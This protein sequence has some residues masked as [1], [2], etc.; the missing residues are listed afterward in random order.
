MIATSYRL[1]VDIDV[2]TVQPHAHNL[3]K[4]IES[5]ATHI[6][7]I[8]EGR[9]QFVEE[10]GQLAERFREV[11]VTLDAPTTSPLNLPGTWLNPEQS[12]VVVRFTDSAYEKERTRAEIH[13]RFSGVREVAARS[14]TLRTMVVALAKSAKRKS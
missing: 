4:Q 11:E 3:A 9:L 5:F 2:Y 1:P 10:M 12:S 8:N 6:A 7:Y 14:M 13:Q